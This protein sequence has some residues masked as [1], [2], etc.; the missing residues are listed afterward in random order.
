MDF[1]SSQKPKRKQRGLTGAAPAS[2]IWS[3][4]LSVLTLIQWMD[5][6]P[7]KRN[8]P[9]IRAMFSPV[10]KTSKS[11]SLQ[12]SKEAQ[13]NSK[14]MERI[15]FFEK[16]TAAQF[17]ANRD[18]HMKELIAM[19]AHYKPGCWMV[20]AARIAYTRN[21]GKPLQPGRVVEGKP[22]PKKMKIAGA[23]LEVMNISELPWGT[24]EGQETRVLCLTDFSEV[25][26][27]AGS[28]SD[29]FLPSS[30]TVDVSKLLLRFCVCIQFSMPN[31]SL[32]YRHFRTYPTPVN[33]AVHKR[34]KGTSTHTRTSHSATRLSREALLPYHVA[35]ARM[36][37]ES[38]SPFSLG[39]NRAFRE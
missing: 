15:K 23:W 31:T 6:S 27:V 4:V 10:S 5:E 28:R 20:E 39:E 37:L 35:Y 29:I 21:P 9:D 25:S 38:G 18:E 7:R 33:V 2:R 22:W 3:L 32:L 30:I 11:T 13:E 14:I 8:E 16:L 26:S 36:I 34:L 1:F 19:K 24:E 12:S 17:K